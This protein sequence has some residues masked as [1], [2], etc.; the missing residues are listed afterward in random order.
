MQET[1]PTPS[2]GLMGKRDGDQ[3]DP[4]LSFC[5]QLMNLQAGKINP[6]RSML[7]CFPLSER[8]FTCPPE[9]VGT[10]TQSWSVSH[11][12][13]TIAVLGEYDPIKLLSK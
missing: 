1:T 7:I 8:I 10:E 6:D 9:H 2:D 11:P 5:T 3:A 13:I 4:Q 12:P